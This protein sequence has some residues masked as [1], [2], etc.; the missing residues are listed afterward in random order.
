[1]ERSSPPIA[2]FR[3]VLDGFSNSFYVSFR[4]GH[5][6]DGKVH[7]LQVTSRRPGLSVRSQQFITE[8]VSDSFA[9]GVTVRAL[10]EPAP[11][12]GLQVRLAIDDVERQGQD[13]T[14]TLHVDT[15]LESLA[16][17]LDTL[18]GGRMRVTIAVEV[19]D[20]VEP[21][22]TNQEFDISFVEAE[23]GTDFPLR[24]P[25]KGRRVAVTV[26]ELKTGT[27]GTA[28]IDLPK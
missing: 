11:Q 20:A 1:M 26:E 14:G 18:N 16:S 21:F 15:D 8:R 9:K 12:G 6:A 10:H 27:R 3:V 19:E 2:I 7:D 28:A 13:F 23:W 5:S 25:A 24:W 17:A 22:T 4:S